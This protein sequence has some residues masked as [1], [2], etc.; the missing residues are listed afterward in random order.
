MEPVSPRLTIPYLRICLSEV[1]SPVPSV[2]SIINV[3]VSR[4]RE[5]DFAKSVRSRRRMSTRM[6]M[7]RG[8]RRAVNTISPAVM[9]YAGAAGLLAKWRLIVLSRRR[10]YFPKRSARATVLQRDDDSIGIVHD[11][12]SSPAGDLRCYKP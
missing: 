11:P 12:L 4:A 8:M 9:E 7:R 3:D 6:L 1:P 5:T 10:R 2:I